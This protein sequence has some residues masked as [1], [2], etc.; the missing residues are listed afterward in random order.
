VLP[1]FRVS[2]GFER[3]ARPPAHYACSKAAKV[4]VF[5]AHWTDQGKIPAKVQEFFPINPEIAPSGLKT[6]IFAGI[7]RQ[8]AVP[9]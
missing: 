4:Q 9:A 6:C 7:Y 2:A 1:C 5:I 8:P 3:L